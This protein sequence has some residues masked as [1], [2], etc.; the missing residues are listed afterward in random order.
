LRRRV[1]VLRKE[2]N[3]RDEKRRSHMGWVKRWLMP[4]ESILLLLFFL[5]LLM[6]KSMIYFACVQRHARTFG[7]SLVIA[8]IYV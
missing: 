5:V 3:P 6:R 2:I 8:M 4:A 7:W 1:E